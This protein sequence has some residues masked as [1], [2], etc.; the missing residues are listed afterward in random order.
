MNSTVT[1]YSDYVC[2]Y[3]FFAEHL[4][5]YVAAQEAMLITAV[6]TFVKGNDILQ[7]LPSLSQ[8]RSF[9]VKHEG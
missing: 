6:P 1:V 5:T 4:I 2:P 7:G 9:L 3:S 8:F